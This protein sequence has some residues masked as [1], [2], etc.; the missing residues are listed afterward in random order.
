MRLEN[1]P[2]C[3][4]CLPPC[5]G[6]DDIDDVQIPRAHKVGD[7]TP[8]PKSWCSF[9]RTAVFSLSSSVRSRI[10]VWSVTRVGI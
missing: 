3:G 2:E 6:I 10:L 7:V 4:T 1:A 8:S 5:V 9:S